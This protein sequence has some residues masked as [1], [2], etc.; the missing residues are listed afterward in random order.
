MHVVRHY[1]DIV[2]SYLMNKEPQIS[3]KPAQHVHLGSSEMSESYSHLSNEVAALSSR[4][5]IILLKND[6]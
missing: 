4:R 1:A 2:L 5:R 3:E 6:F